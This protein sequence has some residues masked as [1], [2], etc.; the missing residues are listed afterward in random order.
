MNLQILTD[1]RTCDLCELAEQAP[2][3]PKSIGIGARRLGLEP[4]APAVVYIGRNPGYNEDD[5]GNPFVGKSGKL[6]HAVYIDGI[7][8]RERAT[9][10]LMNGVRCYTIKDEPP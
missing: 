2:G 5:Q 6:L 8:L 7:N 3:V 1:H 9:I 4:P 10:Y